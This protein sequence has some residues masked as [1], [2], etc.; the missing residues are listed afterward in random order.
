[1]KP[2]MITILFITFFGD[3]KMET[4]EVP[5]GESCSSWYYSNIAIEKNRKYKPFTN[6]NIYTHKYKG[7]NVIGYI[8]GGEEPQKMLNTFHG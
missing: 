3:I 8:C 1:M 5:S 4:F 6:Q 7:K 2:V